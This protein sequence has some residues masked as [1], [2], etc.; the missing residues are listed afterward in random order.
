MNQ[1]T[2]SRSIP[3]ALWVTAGLYAFYLTLWIAYLTWAWESKLHKNF[4]YL[5]MMGMCVFAVIGLLNGRPKG[6]LFAIL[7]GGVGLPVVGGISLV[8]FSIHGGQADDPPG[9]F[10]VLF[11]L[12]FILGGIW[13]WWA[14]TRPAVRQ[15]LAASQAKAL[16]AKEEVPQSGGKKGDIVN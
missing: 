12:V 1:S 11:G 7:W 5:L 9:S 14:L 2:P 15:W 8:V 16:A 3:F 4:P 10:V 6:R 13:H